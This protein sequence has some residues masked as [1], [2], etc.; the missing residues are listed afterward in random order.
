MNTLDFD[1]FD[2]IHRHMVARA[3]VELGSTRRF[4]CSN[5]LGMLEST[6]I[7]QIRGNASCTERMAAGGIGEVDPGI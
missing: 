7:F 5:L 6:A 3:V 2:F 4:M 1:A